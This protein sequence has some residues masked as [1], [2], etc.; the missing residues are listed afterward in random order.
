MAL[1]LGLLQ[2]ALEV[3][4]REW[5]ISLNQNPVRLV[6][7]PKFNNRRDRRLVDGE[8][9]QL[10]SS[11]GQCRNEFMRPLIVL[12]VQTAMRRGELLSTCWSHIDFPSRTLHIPDAKNGTPRTI[13]LT[14]LAGDTLHS[15]QSGSNRAIVKSW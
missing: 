11:C 2:H 7:K 10:L 5:G 12:A 13:P 1:E 6:A 4:R 14:T 9:D 3:A 15:L 8:L